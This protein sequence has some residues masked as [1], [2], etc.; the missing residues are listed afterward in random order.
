MCGIVGYVGTKAQAGGVL[1]DGLHRLEY[2]GYDSAGMFLIA[3]GK[4]RTFRAVGKV[5]AL[6]EKIGDTVPAATV[7]IAHTRW[8]THGKPS[9]ANAHP[10]ASGKVHVVH[11]GIIENY[12]QLKDALIAKGHVFRSETDTEV[13]A[14]IIDEECT[15]HNFE[16]AVYCA[17]GQIRGA[18]ALAVVHEDEPDKIIAVRNSSPLVVGVAKD[19][20]IIASDVA[21][22][23]AYTDRVIY[24]DDGE[25]VICTPDGHRITT[26]RGRA[27]HK[28][29]H[30]IA[31]T[32]GQAQKGGYAHFMLK[33]IFEQPHAMEDAMRGRILLKE[34]MARLGGLAAVDR[35]LKNVQRVVILSCGT[36]YNAGLVG[37]YMLE[38][39]A[40][41]HADVE[42]ASEF[43]YRKTPIDS[44]TAIL[45]ISQSGETADTLAAIREAKTKGALALGIVNVVGSSI[46]RETDAGIYT[47]A[48]PEIGVAST[49]AF[50][51]QLTV[52]ALLTVYMGRSRGMSLTMGK[53]I[54]SELRSVPAK[55]DEIFATK[56]AIKRIAKKY[57]G[58]PNMYYL[59][60]KYQYPIALEGALKIKEISYIHAEGYPAGEL[61][62]GPIALIDKQF[63]SVMIAPHDS[64]FDKMA[65]AIA[66]VRARDGKVIAIT[67]ADGKARLASAAN[68][69]I[70]VPK[71]IEMLM[72]ILT[73]IPMQLLAYYVGVAKGYDVDKPRNLAK[74]VTVE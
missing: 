10:H 50:T 45:A 7:G 11:N 3:D 13:I 25:V 32:E 56:S 22:I 49:K 41:V 8:A 72:P 69:I 5:A 12:Q 19:A 23:I 65:S 38:E 71:T 43:R 21:A 2:R 51:A 36:S 17:L 57:A 70:V 73:T 20:Y 34:G 9:V 40:G 68:D 42:I 28:T 47:H 35:R 18:Y 4:P 60:R 37:K 46:A 55:I 44:K 74:S 63:P 27:R 52:L 33:E 15:Q 30:T 48:G 14:H 29:P 67:T 59:G 61:K 54:L 6:E 39:Y 53:H 64:V 26:A 58:I 1:L 66:E 24:P 62:H 31:W 16:E